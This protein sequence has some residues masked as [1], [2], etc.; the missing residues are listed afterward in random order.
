MPTTATPT[1]GAPT[2]ATYVPTPT[3]PTPPTPTTGAPTAATLAPVADST[4]PVTDRA[5]PTAERATPPAEPATPAA[6]GASEAEAIAAQD[7]VSPH[8]P[9]DDGL[10]GA[11]PVRGFDAPG[12]LAFTFDDGPHPAWTPRVLAALAA[13]DVHATFFVIGRMVWGLDHP[14]RRR[15]LIAI[16]DAGHDIGN[17]TWS[18]ARLTSVGP[19]ERANQIDS[20]GALIGWIIGRPV[21]MLRPPYGSTNGELAAMLAHRGLTEVGWNIDP[22]DWEAKSPAELRK[23]V[24]AAILRAGGGIIILHDDKWI[25]AQALPGILDDLE[26]ANCHRMAAGVPPILPVS[27]HYFMHRPVP[28]WVEARTQAYRDGLEARCAARAEP[29]G[30]APM[31][32]TTVRAGGH[33]SRT[34]HAPAAV[35]A[36]VDNHT[37]SH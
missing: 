16:A 11:A 5:T 13:H 29:G 24:L 7:V 21:H 10:G 8:V 18:H 37:A 30:G 31:H 28:A 20:S 25:T 12:Y 17:H 2:A 22:R 6:D 4:A 23:T 1:T 33:L 36:G 19:L 32:A 27:L 35:A 34:D 3:P 26:A 14:A 9:D 15:E